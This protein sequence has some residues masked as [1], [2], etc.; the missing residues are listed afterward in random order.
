MRNLIKLPGENAPISLGL[1]I[2]LNQVFGKESLPPCVRGPVG[3]AYWSI[4]PEA[5]EPGQEG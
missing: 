5:A 4:Q 2:G 3:S 1:R